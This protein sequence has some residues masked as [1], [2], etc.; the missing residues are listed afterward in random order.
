ML[1][2][3]LEH[4]TKD[5]NLVQPGSEVIVMEKVRILISGLSYTKECVYRKWSAME[6]KENS[7]FYMA[8]G[9]S[10]YYFETL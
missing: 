2:S 6:D 3:N 5:S 10:L 7:T 8:G 1:P 4:V 9:D